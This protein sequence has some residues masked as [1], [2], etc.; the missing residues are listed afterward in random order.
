MRQN[1]EM[2]ASRDALLYVD[3]LIT[4]EN[5]LVD[6]SNPE[7]QNKVARRANNIAIKAYDFLKKMKVPNDSIFSQSKFW[8]HRR[9]RVGVTDDIIK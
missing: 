9:I 8:T 2:R 1:D 4:D 3:T 7:G 6:F 5:K